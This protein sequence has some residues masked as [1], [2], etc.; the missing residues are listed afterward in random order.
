LIGEGVSLAV[1]GTVVQNRIAARIILAIN[2]TIVFSPC[3][4][5]MDDKNLLSPA[6]GKRI[7]K[8]PLGIKKNRDLLRIPQTEIRMLW[9][10]NTHLKH[11]RV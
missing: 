2:L 11:Q 7:D 9:I 8:F 6:P 1:A 10:K 3:D 4:E 5:M